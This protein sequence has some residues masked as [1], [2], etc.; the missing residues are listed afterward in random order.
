MSDRPR[1]KSQGLQTPFSGG[2]RGRPPALQCKGVAMGMSA[3]VQGDTHAD[4]ALETAM[5]RAKAE[6]LVE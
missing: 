5:Q 3:L 6:G 4:G 1:A 2:T